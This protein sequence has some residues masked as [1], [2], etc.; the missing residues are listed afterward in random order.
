MIKNFIA[1]LKWGLFSKGFNDF[2]DGYECV[3]VFVRVYS[4]CMQACVCVCVSRQVH[5]QLDTTSV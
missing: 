4:V 3:C 1:S 2:R 5:F